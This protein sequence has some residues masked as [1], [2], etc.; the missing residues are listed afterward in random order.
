MVMEVVRMQ[1]QDL[2][3]ELKVA[4]DIYNQ[5]YEHLKSSGEALFHERQQAVIV[6]D[7]VEK[8]INSIARSPKEFETEISEIRFHRETFMTACDFAWLMI[9]HI[10]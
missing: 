7:K 9:R 3:N 4:I 6:I 1:N 10:V 2:D 5:E 8:L